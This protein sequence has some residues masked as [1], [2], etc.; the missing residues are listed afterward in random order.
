M[1]AYGIEF[2]EGPDGFGVYAS[3]DV[4]P[5]RR[6]RVR[7]A[8]IQY[9]CLFTQ[10]C[11]YDMFLFVLFTTWNPKVP[12]RLLMLN[13]DH[14]YCFGCAGDHG[15]SIRTD[16]NNKSE[17]SMDVFSRYYTTRPSYI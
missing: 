10:Y 15:D 11:L 16:V 1:R 14:P 2:R 17:T 7:P 5:L 9:K 3:K 8:F 12:V 13:Y 6:A 4:E